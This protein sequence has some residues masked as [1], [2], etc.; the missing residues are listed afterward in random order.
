[1]SYTPCSETPNLHKLAFFS[2]FVICHGC[3][4]AF[5]QKSFLFLYYQYCLNISWTCQLTHAHSLT[6]SLNHSLNY[7]LTQSLTHLF[8]QS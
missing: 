6:H 7:S 2:V 3:P 8:I 1:M 4:T 5:R